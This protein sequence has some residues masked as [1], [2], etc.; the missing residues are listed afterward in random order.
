[1]TFRNEMD[2]YDEELLHLVQHEAG[3]SPLIDFPR[4]PV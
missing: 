1:M 2:S 3:G 4:L